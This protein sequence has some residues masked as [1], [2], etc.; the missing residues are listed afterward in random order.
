MW[1]PGLSAL[2]VV[3]LGHFY[4]AVLGQVLKWKL[5]R[6]PG[7][8]CVAFRP[9]VLYFRLWINVYTEEM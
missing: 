4:C 6:K 9:D 7:L 1:L 2:F 3:N 5:I 8:V